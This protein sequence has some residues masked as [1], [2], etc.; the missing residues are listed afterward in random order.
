MT[1]VHVMSKN[2]CVLLATNFSFCTP[3]WSRYK[4]S[5][6]FPNIEHKKTIHRQKR[7]LKKGHT[8]RDVVN[9]I[10]SQCFYADSFLNVMGMKFG[11]RNSS[12]M[13]R[14]ELKLFRISKPKFSATFRRPAADN[15]YF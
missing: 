12:S 8:V 14:A 6:H 7:K 9:I 5:G 11:G 1:T 15:I 3:L 10:S 4:K 2:S 13:L